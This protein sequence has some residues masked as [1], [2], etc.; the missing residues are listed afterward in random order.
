MCF[1]E[2][3]QT[4]LKEGPRLNSGNLTRVLDKLAS[5]I[6]FFFESGNLSDTI[7]VIYSLL[8]LKQTTDVTCS[9]RSTLVNWINYVLSLL[10]NIFGGLLFK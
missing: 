6:F 1:L 7:D 9:S 3:L 8:A 10:P 2:S 5:H 4:N